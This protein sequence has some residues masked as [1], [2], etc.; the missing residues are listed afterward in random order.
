MSAA[1]ALAVARAASQAASITI[2]PIDPQ[3]RTRLERF[4]SE[5]S[6]ESRHDRFL[7]LSVGVSSAQSR[8]FCRP[9]HEHAEGFVAIATDGTAEGERI[10]GHLC[11][12][13]DG[14]AA[15]EMAVAVADDF[16]RRGIGRRLLA[17]GIAWAH[18]E[19]IGRLTATTY[20]TNAGIHRLV[21]G[22]GMPMQVWWSGGGVVEIAIDLEAQVAA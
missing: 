8:L 12:E 19:G 16:Q 18:R 11:L 6:N 1:V 3:D 5:L 7:Y 10:V 14:V 22:L 4:Y 21:A 13:P 2:R 17:A 15:A 20:T 9:D